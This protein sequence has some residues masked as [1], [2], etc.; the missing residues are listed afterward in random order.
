MHSNRYF[1]DTTT[2]EVVYPVLH[3][4][5]PQTKF[6]KVMFL[7]VSVI[8]STGGGV[9]APGGSALGGVCSQIGGLPQGVFAPR[10]VYSEGNCSQGGLL[11]RICSRGT[12][13]LWGVS[14]LG[15]SV[16]GGS[17]GP[18]PVTATAAGGTHPTGMHSCFMLKSI[19]LG[20]NHP[21]IKI[22]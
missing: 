11:G 18:S 10:G 3:L 15:G 9:S 22:T 13:L 8:L 19:G 1:R 14:A 16:P 12:G 7:H 4:Y 21:G 2:L 5:C 20:N 17:T 6:A